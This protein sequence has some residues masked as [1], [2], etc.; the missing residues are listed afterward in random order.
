MAYYRNKLGCIRTTGTIQQQKKPNSK[1]MRDIQEQMD[2]G[3]ISQS[4]RDS[5]AGS[6]VQSLASVQAILKQLSSDEYKTHKNYLGLM[7]YLQAYKESICYEAS[8]MLPFTNEK[9]DAEI[10][11]DG[12][13]LPAEQIWP[14]HTE[15]ELKGK[16][17]SKKDIRGNIIVD[18]A[19]NIVRN[20]YL[21][22]YEIYK[23]LHEYKK[24]LVAKN[25]PGAD[26]SH[27]KMAQPFDRT[28]LNE[29]K[30]LFAEKGRKSLYQGKNSAMNSI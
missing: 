26:V 7:E 13:T 20:R 28:E 1:Q 18:P 11:S 2:N 4:A 30:S 21:L 14:K 5:Q 15:G 25:G 22:D 6:K 10:E 23:G 17:K 27:M 8:G 29:I 9:Y 12:A 19:G 16:I 3:S 24:K